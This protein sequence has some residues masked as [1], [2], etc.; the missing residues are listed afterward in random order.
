ME[1]LSKADAESLM[2]IPDVGPR[3]S[4]SILTF[5]SQEPNLRLIKELEAH[6]LSMQIQVS[7]KPQPLAG[8]NF[9]ITGTLDNYGRKEMESM[10]KELGGNILSSVGKQLNYLIVGEKPGS[11]LAKAQKLDTVK[12]I[13]EQE[14]LRLMGLE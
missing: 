9:L 3:V 2:N 1:A 5:F 12:I 8:L 10:I 14:A 6:G 11:K 7:D 4:D 13:N